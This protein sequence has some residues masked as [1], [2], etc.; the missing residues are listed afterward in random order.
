MIEVCFRLSFRN[1]SCLICAASFSDEL[2][3]IVEFCRYGDLR[4]YLKERRPTV[5]PTPSEE[6]PITLLDLTSYAFQVAKGMEYLASQKVRSFDITKVQELFGLN[7]SK[8]CYSP[9]HRLLLPL[10]HLYNCQRAI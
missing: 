7:N 9:M 1:I 5:P 8:H 10:V 2:C 6:P 3:V 4:Q